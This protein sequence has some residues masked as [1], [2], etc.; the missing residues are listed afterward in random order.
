MLQNNEKEGEELIC[1]MT[2]C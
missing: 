1:Y 2:Q